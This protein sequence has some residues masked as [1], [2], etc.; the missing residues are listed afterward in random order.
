MDNATHAFA[1]LLLADATVE[2]IERRT[3]R[4]ADRRLRRVAVGLGIVAAELPDADL[5]YSGPVTGLGNLGYLLHHRGHTHTLLFALAS[6]MVMW[7]IVLWLRRRAAGD[8]TPDE[9][10]RLPLL[11]LAV[12]GTLSHIVLDFTNSY[13][14]HPFWPLD[15]R[16]VYGDAVFIVEPW[17]WVIAIPALLFGPRRNWSRVLL[18]LLLLAILAAAWFLG[19][20]TTAL[21]LAVTVGAALW[22]G[23][24]RWIP[25][26]SRTA[27]AIALWLGTELTFG[28]SSARAVNAALAVVPSAEQV[29]DVVVSPGAA[30]P[31]CFD[32]LVITTTADT[33]R[34]RAAT[35]APWARVG[36]DDAP[37]GTPCQ[38]RGSA[39][40][41]AGI[42]GTVVQAPR[43]EGRITW[44]DEWLASRTDF[45]ALARSRCEFAAA[46]R[47]MRVPVWAQRGDTVMLS[48]LR[49]GVGTAGFSDVRISPGSCT[50]SRR[51]WIPPWDPPRADVLRPE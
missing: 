48:D 4:P 30:N 12:I 16:W 37:S 36:T 39:T 1:G 14:V 49:F 35:I 18:S 50:L 10:E 29:V 24:Q 2:W 40:R 25:A 27:A 23:V 3:G 31:F 11:V 42:P 15:N 20:L 38:A 45:T 6:A 44:S 34:V 33:Y 19:Q 7:W 9:R 26:R 17:I 43:V 28:V 32:A 8:S 41:F 22:L 51:A 13:G 21:A 47:F 5:L 46:L